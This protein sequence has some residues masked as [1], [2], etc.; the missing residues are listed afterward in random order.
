MSAEYTSGA[1]DTLAELKTKNWRAWAVGGA[2]SVA[3]RGSTSAG[4]WGAARVARYSSAVLGTADDIQLADAAGGGQWV[5]EDARKG[6]V[7]VRWAGAKGDGSTDDTTALKAAAAV[8]QARG[9]GT[10]VVPPGS[11]RVVGGNPGQ[12]IFNFSNLS[13]FELKA[14]GAIFTSS[15]FSADFVSCTL[16]PTGIGRGVKVTVPSGHGCSVG[17]YINIKDVVGEQGYRGTWIVTSAPNSTECYFDQYSYFV[18]MPA[19]PATGAVVVTG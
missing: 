13:R 9:A 14:A 18:P 1:V 7:D 2:C 4:D 10:L 8:I 12:V 15:D 16:T 11:Y 6:A 5:F 3:V 19:A 17:S